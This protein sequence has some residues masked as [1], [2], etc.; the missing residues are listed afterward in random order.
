MSEKETVEYF[1]CT[2]VKATEKAI[3]VKSDNGDFVERDNG[4]RSKFCWVPIRLLDDSCELREEGDTGP[5][6]VPKWL[7]EDRGWR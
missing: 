3:N 1:G 5:L 2:V 7:A 4:Y 6:I